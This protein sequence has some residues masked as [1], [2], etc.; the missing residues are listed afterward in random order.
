MTFTNSATPHIDLFSISHLDLGTLTLTLTA[1][2]PIS[3]L[4]DALTFELTVEM[5]NYC[6]YELAFDNP[7]VAITYTI[8]S[9]EFELLDATGAT[10]LD[11]SCSY[12]VDYT[13]KQSNGDALQAFMSF[14]PVSRVLTLDSTDA[15]DVNTYTL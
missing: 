10:L 6:V 8:S 9:L 12:G 4:T 11:N 7:T 5:P 2:D 14:D 13:L 3:D 1:T 15:G